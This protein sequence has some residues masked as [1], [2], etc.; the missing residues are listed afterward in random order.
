M[1]AKVMLFLITLFGS[2]MQNILQKERVNGEKADGE[3]AVNTI[4]YGAMVIY[5]IITICSK[6]SLYT[7]PEVGAFFTVNAYCRYKK[8]G[9]MCLPFWK[10]L[11]VEILMC[12]TVLGIS[13][14]NMIYSLFQNS[15][16][17]DI[18]EGVVYAISIGIWSLILWRV[19][20]FFTKKLKSR[21]AAKFYY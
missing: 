4:T 7:F 1:R 18:T 8:K 14:M 10:I 15:V 21:K 6:M 13:Y 2:I 11:R 3:T 19:R 9:K 5:V 20:Y 17:D 12:L 16:I